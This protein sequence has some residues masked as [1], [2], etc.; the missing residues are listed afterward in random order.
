MLPLWKTIYELN[1]SQFKFSR[2]QVLED[3]S[4]FWGKWNDPNNN[5]EDLKLNVMGVGISVGIVSNGVIQN[6]CK[7]DDT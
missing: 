6:I 3:T 1:W 2:K 5:N 4:T 7:N